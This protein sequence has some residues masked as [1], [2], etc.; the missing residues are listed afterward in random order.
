MSP[1]SLLLSLCCMAQR[2][3]KVSHLAPQTFLLIS[4][5]NSPRRTH[6]SRATAGCLRVTTFGHSEPINSRAAAA[7]ASHSTQKEHTATTKNGTLPGHQLVKSKFAMPRC[8]ACT[9]CTAQYD[10]PLSGD[11]NSTALSVMVNST[12][13]SCTIL[14]CCS[15]RTVT[16]AD[17]TSLTM[18][19]APGNSCRHL[20]TATSIICVKGR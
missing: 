14:R 19:S 11:P 6:N 3:R 13:S 2:L 1:H 12:R 8:A 18:R 17:C 20:H 7:A 9:Y 16:S 10:M 4:Q 15:S 5:Q